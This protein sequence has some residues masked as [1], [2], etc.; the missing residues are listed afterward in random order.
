MDVLG[1]V[2]DCQSCGMPLGSSDDIGINADGSGSKDYCTYC[3]HEGEFIEP[4]MTLEEMISKFSMI[5]S[6]TGDLSREEA[7][8]ISK[9]SIPNLKRWK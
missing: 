6:Q 2:Y 8:I 9:Q 5:I 7:E 1:T 3:Y 4:A